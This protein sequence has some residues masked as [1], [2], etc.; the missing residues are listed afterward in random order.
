VDRAAFGYKRSPF[1]GRSC[2]ILEAG[3][4]LRP[5][6]PGEIRRTMETHRRDREAKGHYRCPSAGSAFKNSRD[7]G[8]ATGMIIDE[9]GLRG[10][11][12][13]GAQVAPYHGNIIINAGGA[14]AADIRAL[15]D[16]VARRVKDAAGLTLEPE[17]L[18]VGD[19]S[20]RN[21]VRKQ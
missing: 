4:A 18:F 17:I 9:L 20:G 15:V 12:I 8:K 21:S 19:W 16:E 14:T 13:G 2:L 3:F 11:R 7:F 1:Q 10:L 6:K 5:G